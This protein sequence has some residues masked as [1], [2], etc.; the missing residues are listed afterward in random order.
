MEKEKQIKILVIGN[1]GPFIFR[2]IS[3][4]YNEGGDTMTLEEE[5]QKKEREL[6]ELKNLKRKEGSLDS[7]KKEFFESMEMF[8]K[9]LYEE[10]R[11]E[12]ILNLMT[13]YDDGVIHMKRWKIYCISNPNRINKSVNRKIQ[14]LWNSIYMES[15]KKVT[16][17]RVYGIKN[18]KG[19][20]QV[21]KEEFYKIRE[22]IE[23]EIIKVFNRF[24][25]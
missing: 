20:M 8:I 24:G 13:P 5:I 12:S 14:G 22:L 7:L 10:Y 18:K 23:C 3:M 15:I 4:P 2:Q 16:E 6:E 9:D 21:S 17:N 1:N 11:M 25:S 19:E